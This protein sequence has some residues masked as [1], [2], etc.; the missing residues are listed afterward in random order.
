MLTRKLSEEYLNLY[1]E[2]VSRPFSLEEASRLLG[3]PARTLRFDVHRMKKNLAL[4][5]LERG[6]Y[7]AVEP[8]KW[9]CL[10][11]AAQ[12]HPGIMPFAKE[13]LPK[14][15]S[16]ESIMLYGSRVRGDNRTDSDYDIL[17]VTDGKPLFSEDEVESLKKRGFEVT[18]GYESSL[19]RDVRERPVT[20]VPILR[21]A[22]PIF[23]GRVRGRLLVHYREADLLK[24]LKELAKSAIEN[25]YVAN[26]NDE[27][28]RS[29]LFLAF[30]RFRQLYLIEL[31]MD[32]QVFSIRGWLDR[33]CGIWGLKP[34]EVQRLYGIYKKIEKGEKP[35]TGGLTNERLQRMARGNVS[36]VH[37]LI[38]GWGERAR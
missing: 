12:R 37:D 16:I 17:I 13:I 27:L 36:Y 11:M 6:V 31:L 5:A 38:K 23:D 25:K 29:L 30:S 32:D 8:G 4:E 35:K 1:G 26:P 33:I 10:A 28:K 20:I 15:P 3:A 34:L 21:E 24:D 9:I 22:W 7:R 18:V 19:R 2:F 14:L